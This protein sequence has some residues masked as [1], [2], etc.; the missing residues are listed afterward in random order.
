MGIVHHAVYPI[1]F[2]AARTDFLKQAGMSYSKMEA[3]GLLLPLA[4]MH[5]RFKASAHYEDEI[6]V[7]TEIKKMTYAKVVFEYKVY[8]EA[9]RRLLVEGGTVHACTDRSLKPINVAKSFPELYQ[10]IYTLSTKE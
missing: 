9:D 10:A 5:C 4:E 6:V 2:E 3:D 7:K 8:R 1:W